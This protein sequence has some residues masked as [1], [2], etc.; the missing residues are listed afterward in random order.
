MHAEQP[1]DIKI[2][3]AVLKSNPQPLQHI[4][5]RHQ[6]TKPITEPYRKEPA[7]ICG[8]PRILAAIVWSYYV[9]YKAF[10][11]ALVALCCSHKEV[12]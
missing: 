12:I 9:Q 10:A 11:D 6:C 1:T 2:R 7:S 8:M 5:Q 4:S 3:A